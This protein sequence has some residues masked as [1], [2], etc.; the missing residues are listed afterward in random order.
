MFNTNFPNLLTPAQIV[1]IRHAEKPK[2]GPELSEIGHQR[3]NLLPMYFDKNTTLTE[4]GKP[5]ALY[6][7]APAKA[8]DSLRCI[9]TVIP[10]SAH[11][12][13]EINE[14]YTK[15]QIHELKENI[16]S[17][18]IY[19]GRTVIICWDHLGI[20]LLAKLFG[21]VE[22]PATWDK[23]IYD[24]TWVMRFGKKESIQFINL[25]QNLL[26]GDSKE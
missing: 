23:N 25:P 19:F 13:L 18:P 11:L 12:H 6:A 8:G 9:Q 1:I 16:L 14:H 24:R 21:A 10:L 5:A 2:E 17:N 7:A 4:F 15:N 20:P 3:A 26:P 22:S